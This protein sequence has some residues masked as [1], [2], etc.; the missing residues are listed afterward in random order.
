MGAGSRQCQSAA[1][2]CMVARDV[3]LHTKCK[4]TLQSAWGGM[5]QPA[6]ATNPRAGQRR[7]CH[8]RLARVPGTCN[9]QAPWLQ[10]EPLSCPC[11]WGKHAEGR[12][13][14]GGEAG[15]PGT[16]RCHHA[17]ERPKHGR[18]RNKRHRHTRCEMRRTLTSPCMCCRAR[19]DC[20]RHPQRSQGKAALT[21]GACPAGAAAQCPPRQGSCSAHAHQDHLPRMRGCNAALCPTS[22]RGQAYAC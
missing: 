18:W 5:I 13:S 11:V 20:A 12:K 6:A 15:G 10:Q 21:R 4:L 7:Q 22:D 14:S 19:A 9:Q 3:L 2:R 17:P 8:G 1:P 16:A